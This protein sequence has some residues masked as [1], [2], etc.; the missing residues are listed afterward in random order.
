[1][2][3][4][5]LQTFDNSDFRWHQISLGTFNFQAGNSGYVRLSDAPNNTNVDTIWF[6]YIGTKSPIPDIKVNGSDG[7]ITLDQN[8][9]LTITVSLNNNGQTDNADWWLAADCPYGLYFY[10]FD[11]WTADWVP[12][13]QG[14]L[15]YLDSY[16]LLTMAAVSELQPGTYTVYFG[17]DTN[18]DGDVT[19]DS[20]YYDSVVVNI[21][22]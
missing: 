7:P 11:G 3:V 4:D 13:Y 1:M 2:Y 20:L 14:R 19:W 18:M 16:E 10:T 8:D 22:E 17:V 5:Q 9:T 12:A 21:N 15:F 6:K